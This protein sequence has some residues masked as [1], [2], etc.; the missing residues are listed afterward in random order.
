[1]APVACTV[2]PTTTCVLHEDRVLSP[3]TQVPRTTALIHCYTLAN[4]KAALL[5]IGL[6][7]RDRTLNWGGRQRSWR[8][9]SPGGSSRV[10]ASACLGLESCECG[11]TCSLVRWHPSSPA[12]INRTPTLDCVRGDLT[13]GL[14]VISSRFAVQPTAQIFAV[15]Q[16]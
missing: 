16:P 9:P 6:A 10:H 13:F 7:F 3:T 15:G 14:I 12:S 2:R 11:D 8:T 4:V 1:M 5:G